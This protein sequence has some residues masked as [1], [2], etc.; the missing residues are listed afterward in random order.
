MIP[1]ALRLYFRYVGLSVRAQMQYRASFIMLTLGQVML[2]CI[3]FIGIWTLFKRFGSLKGW[4]LS[5][6]ALFYGMISIAFAIAEGV[7]RGFDTFPN[8]VKSGDFDRLLLRPRSTAFQVA[9]QELQMPRIGRF[10]QAAVVL[11]WAA[12]TLGVQWTMWRVGLLVFAV[13]GGVCL[14]YVLF[15]LSAITAFW[16]TETLEIFATVT[17]GGNE[18]GQ[19]PL[20]IYWPNFRKFFTF[21][22]PLACVAYFPALAVLGRT[23]EAIGSPLWFQCSAPAV[24]VAFMAVMLWLWRVGVKHYQSTGS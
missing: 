2:T 16:T 12:A 10:L 17:Y 9:A 13:A 24:G 20:S 4:R 5:E 21:V 8:M 23:D 22:V 14:F 3:E 1:N 19:Y 7:A 11:A 18:T 6:V 15:V